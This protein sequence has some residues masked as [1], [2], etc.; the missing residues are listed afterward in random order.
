MM[1]LLLRIIEP[2]A[3]GFS[4]QPS[5]FV[6]CPHAGLP[7]SLIILHLSTWHSSYFFRINFSFL[8]VFFVQVYAVLGNQNP[9]VLQESMCTTHCS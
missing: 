3:N 8:F 5:T 6:Q 4:Y 2:Y 7:A 9:H 1:S